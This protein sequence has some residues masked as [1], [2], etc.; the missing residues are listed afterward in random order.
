MPALSEAE[1]SVRPHTVWSQLTIFWPGNGALCGYEKQ[2]RGSSGC[3]LPHLW[4]QAGREVRAEHGPAPHR[5]ASRSAPGGCGRVAT[6]D[7]GLVFHTKLIVFLKN[8]AKWL[9]LKVGLTT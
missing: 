9:N 1:G 6:R 8:C 2:A 7:T 5:P 3:S 4:R